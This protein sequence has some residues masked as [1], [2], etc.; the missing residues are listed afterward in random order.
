MAVKTKCV[1]VSVNLDTVTHS[2]LTV[3][4]PG[5]LGLASWP[6]N[7]PSPFILELRVLLEQA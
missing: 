1:C 6:L 7:S 3:I 5:E 2:V 4:F